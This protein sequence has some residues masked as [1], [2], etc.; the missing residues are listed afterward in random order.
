MVGGSPNVSASTRAKAP[1]S[2]PGSGS[3][4][5]SRRQPSAFATPDQPRPSSPCSAPA[6]PELLATLAVRRIAPR[7]GHLQEERPPDDRLTAEGLRQP[8]RRT[9]VE[10]HG[11]SDAERPV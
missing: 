2:S 11:M 7:E 9:L 8:G 4:S 6:A 5:S 10:L 1:T 3:T